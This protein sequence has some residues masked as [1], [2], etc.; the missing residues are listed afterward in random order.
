MPGFLEALSYEFMRN[1]VLAG[2]LAA[3]LCGMVGTFVVVKRLAFLSDGISHAAFG[4]MGVCYFLGVDPLLGAM[5]VAVLCALGLGAMDTETIRSY[6]AMIGVLWAVGLAVGIVFVYKTPGY[7]PNLM[8]YLFGNIL[9]V[10]R[11]EIGVLLALAVS[12]LLILALFWKGVVAVSFDETFARVQGAPVRL[13]MTMLLTMIALSVVILIQVVGIILV[14]ALLTIPPVIAMMLLK[15]LRAV[16]AVSTAIGIGITL[17]GLGLSFAYD[18]PSGPA[19][20]L[21]GAALLFVVYA[22]RK[23]R[24]GALRTLP[25]L[26]RE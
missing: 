13:L 5:A 15:D 6:D 12:V 1:A 7:A 16:L 14:V 8:T 9:L 3:V 21:L 26:R 19:I 2:L 25:A 22:G 4:G 23:L 24:G 20:I 17:G 11:H 18:L 10:S